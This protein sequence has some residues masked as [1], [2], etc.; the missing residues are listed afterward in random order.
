MND[1]ELIAKLNNLKSITPDSDWKS[2]NRELLL[3]QI[4]N[5]GAHEL[6]AWEIFVINLS[7]I[8]KA[9]T[10]PAYALGVFALVLVTGS[11]F[12]N[13]IFGNTKPNDSL[14]IARIISEKAKLNTMFNSEDRNKLAVQYATEHAQEISAVMADPKFNNESNKEQVAKLNESFSQEIN[15]VK[16]H[17]SYLSTKVEK[18]DNVINVAKGTEVKLAATGTDTVNIA[19]ELKDKDGVQLFEKT[20]ATPV[21]NTTTPASST[22]I[23]STPINADTVL[24]EAQKLFE[25]KNYDG[26]ADKLKEVDALIK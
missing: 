19:S 6:S 5:S 11:L 26:A 16:S 8:A 22:E 1:K 20:S 4:S 9:V 2:S 15:N 3:S 13:Q 12:S 14:Y 21:L 10:K 24:N 18:T 17:I 25:N 7:S 23:I